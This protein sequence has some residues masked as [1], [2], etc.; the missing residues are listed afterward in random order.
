MD[1]N[2]LPYRN[3]H[4]KFYPENGIEEE[5]GKCNTRDHPDLI[6]LH[7]IGGNI[8]NHIGCSNDSKDREHYTA[9]HL[10]G[11]RR[12]REAFPKDQDINM[13][14][15]IGEHPEDRSDEDQKTDG[16]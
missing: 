11:A 13:G 6:A 15:D 3:L 8:Q 12:F 4:L 7:R 14:K 5:N 2:G 1:G 16:I 9:G 10:E